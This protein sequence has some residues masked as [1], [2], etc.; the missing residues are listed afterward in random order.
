MDLY[1]KYINQ[2]TLLDSKRIRQLER[3]EI[4]PEKRKARNFSLPKHQT[5][6]RRRISSIRKPGSRKR[7]F[8]LLGSKRSR[9]LLSSSTLATTATRNSPN[10][11]KRHKRNYSLMKRRMK[12]NKRKRSSQAFTIMKEGPFSK[13]GT[14][15]SS[16]NSFNLPKEGD[17]SKNRHAKGFIFKKKKVK[18]KRKFSHLK[19]SGGSNNEENANMPAIR[20]NLGFFDA[21]CR[22]NILLRSGKMKSL[23]FMEGDF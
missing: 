15:E 9:S 10:L 17:R 22:K 21:R 23:E 16:L 1:I 14:F 5:A 7:S 11:V 3:G 20:S 13:K 12:S 4:L 8:P 6:K 19:S 2:S 18:R